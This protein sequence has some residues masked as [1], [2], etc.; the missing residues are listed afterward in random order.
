[1]TNTTQSI[2]NDPR[3]DK[4]L[5]EFLRKESYAQIASRINALKAGPEISSNALSGRV[6]RLG[7]NISRAQ[8]EVNLRQRQRARAQRRNPIS[9]QDF[10]RSGPPMQASPL[11]KPAPT[12]A[13]PHLRVKLQELTPDTCRF[14]LGAPGTEDGGFCPETKRDK[15]SYCSEYDKR[16]HQPPR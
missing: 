3:A 2:W 16:C 14:F 12:D 10:S 4:I 8:V 15:S 7:L 13:P 5:R 6:S 1:M 9:S 11:P